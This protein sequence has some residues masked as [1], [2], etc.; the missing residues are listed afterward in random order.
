MNV[1]VYTQANC[2]PCRGTK[3]ELNKR[4]IPHSVISLDD[5][6]SALDTVRQLGY[7]SVPVVAVDLGEGASW[8]WSGHQPSQIEK[9]AELI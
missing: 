8:H 7:S 2:Y 6:P 5:D 9:L 4:N 3:R 1:T